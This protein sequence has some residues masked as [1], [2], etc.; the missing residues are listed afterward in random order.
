[1]RGISPFISF[2]LV[3][4][5]TTTTTVFIYPTIKTITERNK[6]SNLINEANS[7]LDLL[8]STIDEISRGYIGSKR[9]ISLTI[10]DGEYYF[11]KEKNSLVFYYNSPQKVDLLGKIGD[12]FLSIG[13]IFYDF[14]ANNNLDKYRII[15]GNWNIKNR[16]EGINGTIYIPINGSYNSIFVSSR[17]SSENN[18]GQLFLDPA[19]ENLVL[20][21]TFDEG[22]GNIVYDYSGNNNHGTY[23]GYNP[24]T[25]YN[26][27]WLNITSGIKTNVTH[28]LNLPSKAIL[29]DVN[30]TVEFRNNTVNGENV[31]VFVNNNYIGEFN[32]ASGTSYNFINILK[33][34]FT[35]GIINNITYEISNTNISRTTI[36][37]VQEIVWVDGIFGK[38]LLFDGVDDY[39]DVGNSTLLNPNK[40]ITIIFWI[41]IF[42]NPDCDANNNWKYLIN[43]EGWGKYHIILEESRKIG[44]TIKN[45]TNT[46]CRWWNPTSIN[47]SSWYQIA[48][49]YNSSTGMG[50]T[51]LN[52][53]LDS[54]KWFP[55][56]DIITD[57]RKTWINYPARASCTN[58]AGSFNG[59]IDE[60][61]I[62]N[63]SLTEQEIKFLYEQ[64]LKKLQN[65]GMINVNNFNNTK[66]VFSNP[67]GKIYVSEII[68]GNFDSKEIN[69]ILPIYN[70]DFISNLKIGK[71]NYRIKIENIGFNET[72]KRP[73]IKIELE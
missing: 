63:R 47:I 60:V 13:T 20:Y 61:R 15:S 10:S 52:G 67:D 51:F 31:R 59:I 7:N 53:K 25:Q 30:L 57:L 55:P 43:T 33:S 24:H 2:A 40:G 6:L 22:G 17:F 23:Y 50:K 45:I 42:S 41:N 29:S 16:L 62:Y 64:G 34:N 1:M 28:I 54:E 4:L 8:F 46:D 19:P 70:V 71:G 21:L 9:T 36:K 44:M 39:V 14:F 58:G 35:A 68:V 26:S 3:I 11:D 65:S 48:M 37:Y 49:S 32:S 69:L 18:L 56:S 72:S 38:A 73:I 5:I 12:K 27:T 66:I